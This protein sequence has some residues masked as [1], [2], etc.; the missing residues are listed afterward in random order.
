MSM[1][2]RTMTI[3]TAPRFKKIEDEL[4]WR[5]VISIE[6]GSVAHLTRLAST[7]TLDSG[8][9]A[10]AAVNMSSTMRNQ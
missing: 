3:V 9:L 4:G 7:R 1:V 2:A 5:T 8:S 6:D 10:F